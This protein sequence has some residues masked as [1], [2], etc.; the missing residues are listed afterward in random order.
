MENCEN[1]LTQYIREQIAL[2][3]HFCS[4][5][6]EQA[7]E[8][9]EEYHEVHTLIGEMCEVL[10]KHYQPLND[11]LSQL[12]DADSSALFETGEG[13]KNH[14]HSVPSDLKKI[15]RISKMLRDD[16]SAL[17]HIAMSNTLLHTAALL[18]DRQ[19]VSKL[20]L[21]HLMNLTPLVVRI[22]E[23]LPEVVARELQNSSAKIDPSLAQTAI[24]NI[25]RAWSAS[26]LS[27]S[28]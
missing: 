24:E 13:K 11:I 27:S 18:V 10:E 15:P 12:E 21:E 8:I 2:E 1:I 25:R 6:S 3:E 16:Y 19:E 28:E 14:L 20:A 23:I 4:L 5:L 17:S 26:S 9:G 7:T 22:N